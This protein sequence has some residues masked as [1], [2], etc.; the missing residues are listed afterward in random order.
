M[1][2]IQLTKEQKDKLLEMCKAL[3]TEYNSVYFR[4]DSKSTTI[5]PEEKK[6]DNNILRIGAWGKLDLSIHWFEFCMTHLQDK[7]KQLGGF[8]FPDNDVCLISS[9]FDSHPVDLI[10]EEFKKLKKHDYR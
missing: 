5:Y 4:V 10:Y 1:T 2:S 8:D 9:W 6:V 3:F 7:I